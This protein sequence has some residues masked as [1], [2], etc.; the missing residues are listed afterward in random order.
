MGVLSE[1]TGDGLFVSPATAG[2]V[3]ANLD[4]RDE[5]SSSRRPGGL[6]EAMISTEKPG[7]SLSAATCGDRLRSP[8]QRPDS[9]ISPSETGAPGSALK[10]AHFTGSAEAPRAPSLKVG[11]VGGLSLLRPGRTFDDRP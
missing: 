4:A 11:T 3:S 7:T 10:D 8:R 6:M 1:G 5:P 2:E 9:P